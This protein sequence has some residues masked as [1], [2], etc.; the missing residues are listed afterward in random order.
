MSTVAGDSTYSSRGAGGLRPLS[1]GW[2]GRTVDEEVAPGK[3][4]AL[5]APLRGGGR[6]AALN[7]FAAQNFQAWER[8]VPR[9]DVLK[10]LTG[11]ELARRWFEP[12]LPPGALPWNPRV[13]VS[14]LGDALL[15]AE[16][17]VGLLLESVERCVMP[18][19][20]GTDVWMMREASA[21][22][23]GVNAAV[24]T[25]RQL[26]EAQAAEAPGWSRLAL[27]LDFT[28]PLPWAQTMA[29][30]LFPGSALRWVELG[31][32]SFERLVQMAQAVRLDW[33]ETDLR[34]FGEEIGFSRWIASDLLSAAA[35]FDW[36]LERA[37]VNA[38]DA[39]SPLDSL[40][41][42]TWVEL[43]SDP[44]LRALYDELALPPDGPGH[45]ID[46]GP[47]GGPRWERLAFLYGRHLIRHTGHAF[48]GPCP[49]LRRW[50]R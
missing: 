30:T 42:A 46:P 43:R 39:R 6:G 18:V 8:Q 1:S 28:L 47:L 20:L 37:L 40:L 13:I 41:H 3:V 9:R 7:A 21:P 4:V 49:L 2:S 26:L 23:V 35:R 31:P 11:R 36:S 34:A 48:L 29:G 32:L 14:I 24:E 33:P 15:R 5:C 45:P 27:A 12:I 44:G 16:R 17:P 19:E 22:P 50:L 25:L 10:P 38:L